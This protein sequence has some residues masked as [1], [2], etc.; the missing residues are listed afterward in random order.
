MLCNRLINFLNHIPFG[1]VRFSPELKGLVETSMTVAVIKTLNDHFEM[2]GSC[3]SSRNS[4][5]DWMY[6]RLQSVCEMCGYVLHEKIGSYPG[7]LSDANSKLN[8]II[9]DESTKVYGEK[10]KVYSIHAGLECGIIKNKY[11]DM[12][13]SSIGPEVNNAHSPEERVKISSVLP[14]YQTLVG[15]LRELGKN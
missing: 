15:S 1:V 8:K 4:Q 7:W 2:I 6:T 5:L 3:R 9:I 12:D 14:C 10:P 11:D 13:C